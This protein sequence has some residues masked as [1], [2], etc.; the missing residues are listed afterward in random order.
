MSTQKKQQVYLS[1]SQSDR[2]G[3]F[4]ARTMAWPLTEAEFEDYTNNK[5]MAQI[6]AERLEFELIDTPK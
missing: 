3:F 6:R 5:L 4:T 1:R 2:P